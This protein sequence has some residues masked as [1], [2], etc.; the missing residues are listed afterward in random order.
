MMVSRLQGL[1]QKLTSASPFQRSLS[2]TDVDSASNDVL[3]SQE[4][5]AVVKAFKLQSAAELKV[6]L[7]NG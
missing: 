3:V 4:T 7:C 2:Q 1:R 6:L 5:R